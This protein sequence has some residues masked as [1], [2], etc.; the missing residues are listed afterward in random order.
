MWKTLELWQERARL[1]NSPRMILDEL[2][3]I[4]SADVVLPT[5]DGRVLKVRCVVKPEPSQALLLERLGIKLPQRLR[6]RSTLPV[7]KK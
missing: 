7:C 2:R 1:G 6:I 5:T 3:E 4:R